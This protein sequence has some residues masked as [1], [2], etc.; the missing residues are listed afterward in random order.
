MFPDLSTT[1]YY[2]VKYGGDITETKQF[3]GFKSQS[4]SPLAYL[5]DDVPISTNFEHQPTGKSLYI[6]THSVSAD[7]QWIYLYSRITI[8]TSC[9][10]YASFN[11]A[12]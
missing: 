2:Q 9:M 11:R 6:L 4:V 1:R 8:T 10:S 12:T 5:V 7:L 3:E